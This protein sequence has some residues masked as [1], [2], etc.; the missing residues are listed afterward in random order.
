[1]VGPDAVETRFAP[2]VAG[3]G[4]MLASRAGTDPDRVA[5]VGDHRQWTYADLVALG[6]GVRQRVEPGSVIAVDAP[7]RE[8]IAVGVLAA[9]TVGAAA[10]LAVDLDAERRAALLARFRPSLV[11]DVAD[12]V[13]ATLPS[14]PFDEP[15]PGL[16]DPAI[17][18]ATSGSTAVP[19]LVPN[20]HRNLWA[21][22]AAA[23]RGQRLGP[24]DRSLALGSVAHVLGLR[25]LTDALWC[26]GCAVVPEAVTVDAVAAA[27]FA[28]RPTCVIASPPLFHVVASALENLTSDE[29]AEVNDS[30]R[31]LRSGAAAL[32]PAVT[33]LLREFVDAPVLHGYGMSEAAKIAC[34]TLDWTAPS[35][36]VG[37]AFG[38]ELRL[39][40]G[41]IVVRGDCVAPGYFDD[42]HQSGSAF[43][44]GWFRTGD[45]GRVDDDGNVFLVGRKDEVVSRGG[46][47]ISLS[48]IESAFADHPGV[49]AAL[50]AP[51]DHP[52]LGTDVV[53][54]YVPARGEPAP[55]IGELR[56]YLSLRL[57]TIHGPTRFMRLEAL[58]LSASMKPSRAALAD[59]VRKEAAA[60]SSTGVDLGPQADEVDS[61]EVRLAS[62]WCDILMI[63]VPLNSD[64][65]FFALGADSLHLVEMCTAIGNEFGFEVMPSELIERPRLGDMAAL[66][67]RGPRTGPRPMLVRLRAG[68]A[69]HAKLFVVPGR[70]GTLAQAQRYVMQLHRG[71]AMYGFEAPG[72][73][74]GE[75]PV[76][77][78]RDLARLYIDALT[79]RVRDGEPYVLLGLSFGSI[80]V[81][82]MGAQLERAGR[83]LPLVV[84]FDCMAPNL[85]SEGKKKRVSGLSRRRRDRAAAAEDVGEFDLRPRIHRAAIAFGH[86]SRRHRPRTTSAPTVMF[87]TEAHRSRTSDPLLGWTPYLQGPVSRH[88]FP[89]VH[90]QL[91]RALAPES[92]STLDRVLAE[93]DAGFA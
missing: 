68:S 84:M 56:S 66:V 11:L 47:L 48:A 51:V 62:L 75:R 72:M 86:A 63:N 22:A 90:R 76:N 33:T 87:T 34:E 64:H 18:V 7:T 9:A 82:E 77:R 85:Q 58:P 71:R 10:P 88:D 35:G 91:I 16:D 45:F 3:L 67:R 40:D 61:A 39:D 5:I 73:Y 80:V 59:L 65:D 42:A 37:R 92:G 4:E 32:H 17:I 46:E 19:K 1:M 23:A 12:L 78:I 41:E 36:S 25:A 70:G 38:V 49:E 89:G 53:L 26:G 69:E 81:Q 14:E 83:D 29:R 79:S 52:S 27:L 54:G 43:E 93:Y 74:R 15:A 6:A 2:L 55:S 13:Q 57:G 60:V 28:H 20:T 30:L 31:F 44:D 24:D 50:A 8:L 21:S